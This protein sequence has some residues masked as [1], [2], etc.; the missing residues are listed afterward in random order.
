MCGFP[1]YTDSVLE[2]VLHD[3]IGCILWKWQVALPAGSK[4]S[5]QVACSV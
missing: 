1:N 3:D 4:A 5:G 2:G